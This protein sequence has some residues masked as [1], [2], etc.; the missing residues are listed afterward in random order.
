MME[1]APGGR[2]SALTMS[3]TIRC[4]S[5]AVGAERTSWAFFRRRCVNEGLAKAAMVG[6]TGARAGLRS[7]RA[8]VRRVLPLGVARGLLA[9][10]RGDRGGPLRSTAI[11][12][13]LTYTTLGYLRGRYFR[14]NALMRSAYCSS[15]RE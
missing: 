10:L 4:V 11:L 8:Y 1:I 7:E 12:A 9:G 15:S 14:R 3:S 5:H 6:G 2:I 13:G